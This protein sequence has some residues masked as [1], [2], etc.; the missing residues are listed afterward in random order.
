MK[1]RFSVDQI[2]GIAI[3]IVIALLSTFG[4][5]EFIRRSMVVSNLNSRTIEYLESIVPPIEPNSSIMIIALD[6]PSAKVL[7]PENPVNALDRRIY[8]RL[9]ED[10]AKAKAAVVLSDIIFEVDI[11]AAD[12]ELRAS[13]LRAGKMGTTQFFLPKGESV[14]VRNYD[15]PDDFSYEFYITPGLEKPIPNVHLG[16]VLAFEADSMVT[17]CIPKKIN[18]LDGK[19]IWHCALLAAWAQYRLKPEQAKFEGTKL[20]LPGWEATLGGNKDFSFSWTK[21][22]IAFPIVSIKDAIADL[23]QGNYKK[24][25]GKLILVCDLRKN[26][27]VANVP[28]VGSVPGPIVN[29]NIVNT[30]LTPPS[31]QKRWIPFEWERVL[32]FFLC[33]S[34]YLLIKSSHRGLMALGLLLPWIVAISLPIYAAMSWRLLMPMTWPL[35]SGIFIAVIALSTLAWQVGPSDT[36]NEGELGE[37]TVLF[38]DLEDSTGWVVSLGGQRYQKLYGDWV[39]A[40]DSVVSQHGGVLE[41]T[42]GDGFVAVF[43]NQGG[44]GIH[45]CLK[46]CQLMQAQLDEMPLVESKKVSASFGFEAGP[47]SG[48]YVMEAGRKVWSSSGTTVNMARRLQSLAGE[49]KRNIVFGPVAS[50]YLAESM[51]LERLGQRNLKGIDHPVDC[52]SLTP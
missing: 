4:I 16:H 19:P 25:E 32:V 10:L 31:Q 11:P 34:V 28:T 52:F 23:K 43:A 17:G 37:A 51:T 6:E 48:G 7:I 30:A 41:R 38:C 46:A 21:E 49:E 35:S 24:Y 36:R 9:F 27:D 39:K 45:S 20:I 40:C 50:R 29:A 18:R 1:R 22:K 12:K 33:L 14:G 44:A 47:V 13:L 5:D 26:E 2:R 3:A 15:E 8:G 42:T